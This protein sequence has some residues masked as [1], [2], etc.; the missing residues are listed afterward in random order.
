ME[1]NMEVCAQAISIATTSFFTI[2]LSIGTIDP[3]KKN[4]FS[5]HHKAIRLYFNRAMPVTKI[6]FYHICKAIIYKRILS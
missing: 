3:A 2:F 5:S 6:L 1:A 4:I